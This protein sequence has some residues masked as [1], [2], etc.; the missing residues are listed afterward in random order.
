[1]E[2]LLTAL[3][4]QLSR[5]NNGHHLCSSCSIL[6]IIWAACPKLVLETQLACNFSWIVFLLWPPLIKCSHYQSRARCGICRNYWIISFAFVLGCLPLD[7]FN[8]RAASS[9][10]RFVDHTRLHASE[11][12]AKQCGLP[13]NLLTESRSSVRAKSRVKKF[14]CFVSNH[15]W[16]IYHSRLKRYE[17]LMSPTHFL[18]ILISVFETRLILL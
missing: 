12:I 16:F 11:C 1:M 2:N 17:R 5:C 7:W 10:W 8:D 15:S 6:S 9:F 3:G 18:N 13:K 14:I 4:R